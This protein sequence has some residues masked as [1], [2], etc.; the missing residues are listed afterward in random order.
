MKDGAQRRPLQDL[1]REQLEELI[2]LY[3]KNWLALDGVWFQAAERRYGMDAAMDLDEDAWRRYT[4]IEAR[5]IKAFLGLAERPGLAGLER[6]LR[7]RFYGQLN[8][9]EVLREEN[10]LIYRV[11]DC[12]V[13][14]ART[15]KGMPLHPCKRVGLV[16]YAGFARAIDDR[17][18]CECLSCL[19]AGG[20]GAGAGAWG[21]AL[22]KGGSTNRGAPP[23]GWA[24]APAAVFLA[25]AGWRG[26]GPASGRGRR[27]PRPS[28]RGPGSWR[29]RC[30]SGSPG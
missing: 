24:G 29:S 5:R 8:C 25:I 13:Q 2:G 26:P 15:R 30:G 4:E 27:A 7:L 22:K 10:A 1:S 6:A 11:V 28:G 23:R 9:D 21:S 17:L 12:R 3:A 18:T 14:S 16:E 19:R 20:A